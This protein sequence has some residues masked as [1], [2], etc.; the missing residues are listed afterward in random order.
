MTPKPSY[1][2]FF[3]APTSSQ[4]GI[5][6]VALGLVRAFQREGYN[7]GF[8]KPVADP[9]AYPDGL[10]RSVHFARTLLGLNTPDP[11]PAERAEEMIRTGNLFTL[12]EEIVELVEEAG[13]HRR[14]D[15]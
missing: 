4:Q 2:T 3:L 12:L 8:A 6:S 15:R 7:V 5:S 1:R 11:I 10:D 14:A 9:E 13:R